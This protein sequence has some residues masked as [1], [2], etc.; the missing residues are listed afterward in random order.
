M[1][2]DTSYLSIFSLNVG[3]CGPEQTR[4]RTLLRSECHIVIEMQYLV[5]RNLVYVKNGQSC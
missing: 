2:R 4:M 3:E 1:Q 5:L